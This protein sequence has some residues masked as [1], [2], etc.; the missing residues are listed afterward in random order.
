[1]EHTFDDTSIRKF[2]AN[3][4]Y[5]PKLREGAV[6]QC[7]TKNILRH[8]MQGYTLFT[9]L[10]EP[11][12][13]LFTD[14]QFKREYNRHKLPKYIYGLVEK[15]ST[16]ASCDHNYFLDIIEVN[17]F[18]EHIL[19][20]F[21]KRCSP[22]LEIWE[23]QVSLVRNRTDNTGIEID[24]VEDM[25]KYCFDQHQ[26]IKA[27][28]PYCECTGCGYMD[29]YDDLQAVYSVFDKMNVGECAK[30]AMV[31]NWYQNKSNYVRINC[32]DADSRVR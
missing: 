7:E 1:M 29:I 21:G 31:K 19:K 12:K 23:Y 24:G 28:C 15:V 20:G 18:G 17:F 5:F 16:D 9:T 32:V 3:R 30:R 11:G 6:V 14:R 13:M 26:W 27:L 10:N 25:F 4:G 22:K 2:I 8:L